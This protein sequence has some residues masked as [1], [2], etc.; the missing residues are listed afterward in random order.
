MNRLPRALIV[1]NDEDLI[2]LLRS[3]LGER[4]FVVEGLRS[5]EEAIQYALSFLPHVILLD[6]TLPD[7]DGFEVCSRL[8]RQP[9]TAHIPV[10]FLTNRARR[11]DKLA[12]LSLGA[13]DYITKPFDL[14]ELYLRIRN[15]V[16]HVTRE[17]TT[18]PLTGLPTGTMVRDRITAAIPDAE[19]AVMRLALQHAWAFRDVYGPL[20]FADIRVYLTRLMM[21]AVD[22]AGSPDDFI[23]VIDPD[24]F[25]VIASP[26]HIH[27]V[28]QDVVDTF[29]PT[30]GK[31]Y[32]EFDRYHGYLEVDGM[33][34]PIMQLV[35]EVFST[36][37]E[38]A[39]FLPPA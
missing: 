13:D 5:G 2:D 15:T 14:H 10:I 31:H 36:E 22:F 39:R 30:A 4:G 11:S 9:R 26:A 3:Y 33:H 17:N 38:K 23:G 24:V 1:G 34:V 29:N 25:V 18:D 20:A 27:T 21:N 32:A 8:R 12:G 16:D 35:Y 19:R 6:V 28:G 37:A 7:I